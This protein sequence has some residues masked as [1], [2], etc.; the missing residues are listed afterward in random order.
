MAT[1]PQLAM[2]SFDQC[3][4]VPV[5]YH[6][7]VNVC[8][9]VLKTCYEAGVRVFE[10]TNRGVNA[11]KNFEVLQTY[12]K[13]HFPG[14]LLGIG[15]IKQASEAKT[16]IDLDTDFIVSPI[17]DGN[18]AA[19]CKEHDVLWVPGCMTPT[20]VAQAEQLGAGFVKLFPGN[21]LGPGFLKSIKP[22]FPGLK[23]MPTGGVNVSQESL[24]AWFLAGV[25][26]VG[27]GSN[28]LTKEV[29]EQ[30][31]LDMLKSKITQTFAYIENV[32]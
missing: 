6:D 17:V 29:I 16:Y 7:D 24:S 8:K 4:M 23:F 28:L 25:T 14:L 20:E 15:T 18:T 32:H 3:G 27:M 19:T 21:I 31:D 12:K 11:T 9:T 13:E 22:L 2:A 30:G 26:C 10:F 5:F 1:S